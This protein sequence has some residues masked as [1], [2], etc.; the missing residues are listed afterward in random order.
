MANILVVDDEASM[1]ELLEIVLKGEGHTVSLAS[2]GH[3]AGQQ[4]EK[5]NYDLV[6]SDINMPQGTGIELLKQARS[7]GCDSIFIFITAYASSESAIEALKYGAFD[8][9][10]K[11]F[12]VDELR[13]LVKNALETKLLRQQ[14]STLKVQLTGKAQLLGTSPAMIQIYKLIGTLAG[15]ESTILVTGESGTGKEL[16]ARAIHDTSLRKGQP[17]VSINCGAFPET[18]LESELFGYVRG[19]F[20]GAAANKKGLIEAADGGSLFLDEIG[21]MPLPM[22]VKLLRALQDHR[23]RPVGGTQEISVDVRVIA[24]TNQDLK[25]AVA[26]GQFREDLYYRI[27][28]IPL[29]IPPLRERKADIAVLAEHFVRRYA[30]AQ[31]KNIFGFSPRV[32]KILESY[33][34]PGNVRE[35]ENVVERAVALESSQ[36]IQPERLPEQLL[37]EPVELR[38]ELHTAELPDGGVDYESTIQRIETDLIKNAL[39]KTQ[40]NQMRAARLL[41]LSYRSLR[42]K[43]QTLGIKAAQRPTEGVKKSPP[44]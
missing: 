32:M 29:E 44:E 26:A 37:A 35:L 11:P 27:A 17:F 12:N 40:G 16:V 5:H 38:V 14:V 13:N 19:A 31:G 34:W 41:N 21:D 3:A 18:L 30:Q 22:Q 9:I 20:T 2:D 28:V 33:S 23:V 6:V 7:K 4:L 43:I 8:Y 1:R 10:T 15:T 36:L 42:H 24:A 39:K 25:A